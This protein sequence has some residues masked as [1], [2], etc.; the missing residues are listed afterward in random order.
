MLI[1][2]WLDKHG[3]PQKLPVVFSRSIINE[4][5]SIK[6]FNQ[7]NIEAV[8]KLKEYIDGLKS[9][10]ANPVIAWDYT[11]KYIRFPNGAIHLIELGFDVTF[12]VTNDKWTNRNYIYVFDV[13][14][15]PER[16]GLKVPPSLKENKQSV[17]LTESYLYRI[18]EES[19]RSVL[20]EHRN[21]VRK[22][23]RHHYL[24]S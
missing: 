3:L 6:V 18:I 1:Q 10:I 24:Y 17:R 22:K 9:Y 21:I 8:T 13:K 19:V 20:K 2:D 4:I 12:I 16:F 7:D 14:L 5:D 15:F 23:G 11:N